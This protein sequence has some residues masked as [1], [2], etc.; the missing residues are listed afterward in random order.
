MQAY[1]FRFYFLLVTVIIS[2]GMVP[3]VLA[4]Q[5]T[6]KGFFKNKTERHQR[7]RLATQ[8]TESSVLAAPTVARMNF[9][10]TPST[11]SCTHMQLGSRVRFE[12]EIEL[13]I[14]P[15]HV[16]SLSNQS[17]KERP[18]SDLDLVRGLRASANS[19]Q[20]TKRNVPRP[21][22]VLLA[23]PAPVDGEPGFFG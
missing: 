12:I 17:K 20:P 4:M 21:R 3:S 18:L 14:G 7:L 5:L 16:V 11:E 8:V 23:C 22:F 13:E 1:C 10:P 2:S 9:R 6:K 19:S 15:N